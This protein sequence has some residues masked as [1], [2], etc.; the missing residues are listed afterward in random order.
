MVYF[1]GHTAFHGT[2]IFDGTTPFDDPTA[3]DD[4]TIL[5]ILPL[6]DV[7]IY[8]YIY[9]DRFPISYCKASYTYGWIGRLLSEYSQ[10]R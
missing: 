5:M 1:D 6:V 2:T 7:Y 10:S 3:S 4:T 8:I 9:M